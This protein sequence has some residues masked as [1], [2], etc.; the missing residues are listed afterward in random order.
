M[1]AASIDIGTNS[2]LLLVAD[3]SKNKLKVLHEIQ[4]LPRLGEGVDKDKKLGVKSCQRVINV[5]K[6]YK[7]YLTRHYPELVPGTIVTATSA[8]R[9]ASNRCSFLKS[10]LVETG[11]NIRLLSGDEEAQTTYK[12]ALTV[13]DTTVNEKYLILDIGGGSTEI[14]TG[15]GL[16]LNRGISIDMGSVRYT[17]RFFPDSKADVET[18]NNVR[19]AVR[20]NLDRIDLLKKPFTVVGVAGTVTSLAAVVTELEKYDTNILN[21]YRLNRSEVD[22]CIDRFLDKTSEEIEAINPLFLRGRGDV[23]LAGAIILSEFL[24]WCNSDTLVVSTGGIRHGIIV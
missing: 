23:I 8:V 20:N 6:S 22:K 3:V 11:W 19:Q 10:V 2:V 7:A 18:T 1:K 21:G 4:E 24:R 5:L 14:A 13:L 15:I 16:H 9:D 12:G 17:E